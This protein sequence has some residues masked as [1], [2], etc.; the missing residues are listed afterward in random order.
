[1][2][3]TVNPTLKLNYSSALKAATKAR[4][5][6]KAAWQDS[7]DEKSFVQYMR[8]KTLVEYIIKRTWKDTTKPQLD[9]KS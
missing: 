1:M 4:E 7:E 5:M 2:F 9:K 3:I 6:W 8:Y